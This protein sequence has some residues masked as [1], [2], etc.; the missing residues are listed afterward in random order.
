M[1]H[2]WFPY[3]PNFLSIL[4][5]YHTCVLAFPSY[6][7]DFLFLD[8]FGLLIYA[9]L[10]L[11]VLL[12]ID[13]GDRVNSDESGFDPIHWNQRVG[14]YN[15]RITYDQRPRQIAAYMIPLATYIL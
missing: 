2:A 9:D 3:S 8:F 1:D 5:F 4:R 6:L 10:S 14:P 7:F 13:Q 15:G 12:F 11:S